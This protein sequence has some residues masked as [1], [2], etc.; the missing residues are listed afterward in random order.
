MH[1]YKEPVLNCSI[2][3]AIASMMRAQEADPTNLEVLLALGVSYTNGTYQLPIQSLCT[4]LSVSQ[5]VGHKNAFFLYSQFF[6]VIHPAICMGVHILT[7]LF[8]LT[9]SAIL[10]VLLWFASKINKYT[11]FVV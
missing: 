5:A 6:S 8:D 2:L 1:V 9:I 11:Y 4:I 7:H 10:Y 3:Q